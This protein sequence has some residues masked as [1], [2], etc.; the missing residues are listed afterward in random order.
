MYGKGSNNC[1]SCSLLYGNVLKCLND[2][3]CYI[4]GFERCWLLFIAIRKGF[5]GFIIFSLLHP[6]G[7][8]NCRW[9]SLLPTKIVKIVVDLRYYKQRFYWCWL[10]FVAISKGF[11]QWKEFHAYVQES[12]R[13]WMILVAISNHFES[14]GWFLLLYAKVLNI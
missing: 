12:W 4:Q 14:V 1:G 6:K 9:F 3:R 5:K 7:F 2:F 13:C 8:D 10:V 11:K